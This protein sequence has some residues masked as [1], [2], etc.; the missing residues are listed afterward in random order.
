MRRL[1]C[2]FLLFWLPLQMSWSAVANYC[3][4]ESNPAAQHHFGH[5]EH[6]HVDYQH[7]GS[8]EQGSDKKASV[9]ND[10][11]V[12][13]MSFASPVTE[14]HTPVALSGD[15]WCSHAIAGFA[16]NIPEWPERPDI[17]LAA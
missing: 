8:K 9:D 12:C 10:C 7:G 5:H 17:R 11:A 16:S 4:H 14:M 13:H 6:K 3:Q 1:L 15:E 2:L